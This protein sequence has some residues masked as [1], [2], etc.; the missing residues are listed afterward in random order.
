MAK[1]APRQS[2]FDN[3]PGG[4]FICSAWLVGCM[5]EAPMTV[6]I[7][8]GLSR[9]EPRFADGVGVAA[10]GFGAGAAAGVLGFGDG[11][12]LGRW[13]T[14]PATTT[15]ATTTASPAPAAISNRLRDAPP[16]S[17]VGRLRPVE[18]SADGL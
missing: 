9:I 3:V 6:L 7:S 2:G 1:S 13:V 12:G 10:G 4:T 17:E 11:V 8:A 5:F 14:S 18:G 15:T 16:S